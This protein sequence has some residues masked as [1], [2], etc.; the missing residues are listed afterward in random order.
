MK[1]CVTALGAGLGLLF[2]S[3]AGAK[4]DALRAAV[5]RGEMLYLANCTICHGV[6]GLGVPGTY[7]PLAGSD[8]LAAN[9]AEAIRAV[10]A[11]LKDEIVVNGQAY[12]G[13]MPA[14]VLDDEQVADTLTYV[15]NTWD[16]PGGRLTA[17]EVGAVRRKTRFPTFAA[18][19]AASDFRELPAPPPGFSIAELARLPDFATRLAS[20]GKG[21]K[22][23]VL[24]ETGTVWRLDVEAGNFKP[25]IRP[26]D[27]PGMPAA[28]LQTLGMTI[29]PQG[30]LW[31]TANARVNAQPLVLNEVGIFRTSAFD[32]DGDPVAPKPWFRTNYPYG[33]GPYNHGLSDIR[34]G[35][36]G[37]L[38][39][40]SGSRTDAGEAG[41]MP[42]LGRMGEVDITATVWRFDPAAEEPR[43][44]I[45]ARGIRN[46]YSLGWD[47]AGNL[48]TISNGPDA[49]AP[50]EMDVIVP[51]RAG[52]PPAHHGFPHQ[53]GD[54]PAEHKWYPHTPDA[55]PGLK[56][57]LPVVNLG[58]A[59]LLGGRPTSTFSP[60]SCPAGLVWLGDGWPGTV[61]HSFL[62]GRFGNFIHGV[63]EPDTGFDILCAKMERRADGSWAARMTTFLAPLGRP[64]DLHL[65]DNGRIF[66]LEYTRATD[67]K[68]QLGRL[69]GR[70]LVLTA[71]AGG[72]PVATQ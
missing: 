71:R 7:P 21:R 48:F 2:A 12:A 29:D 35:P 25:I 63:D 13:Q 55:P 57:A 39:V 45:I 24:G 14:I 3:L 6:T 44:E 70:I 19:K 26:R 68:S 8:W 64:I 34:F 72:A 28:S 10:V 31:I 9:R 60:H 1:K 38:Y 23:Y 17:E 49:H 51:P 65:A 36:D 11:G 66:V 41:S 47:G 20:D 37:R 54:T 4:D 15:F 62:I 32:A 42:H 58:P 59:A 5:A 69:P 53:F 67:F 52:E 18:L 16:N 56:F 27:Y 33:I 46:A 50:E 40:S 30:R 22:L 61:R 43:I